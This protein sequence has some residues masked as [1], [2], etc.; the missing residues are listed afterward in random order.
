LVLS[1]KCVRSSLR[2]LIS[3]FLEILEYTSFSSLESD[4]GSAS[5]VVV[6]TNPTT[7][8][9]AS[10]ASSLSDSDSLSKSS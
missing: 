6:A 8:F 4:S 5:E 9:A 7:I 3:S 1:S 2:D 10:S